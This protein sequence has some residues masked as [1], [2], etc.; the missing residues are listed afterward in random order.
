MFEQLI[1]HDEVL[2]AMIKE[3]EDS[4]A[5]KIADLQREL[6]DL[7]MARS[8]HM[9]AKAK[10]ADKDE[11]MMLDREPSPRFVQ[12]GLTGC[13]ID[14]NLADGE[15]IECALCEWLYRRDGSGGRFYYCSVEH[16]EDDF[17]SFLQPFFCHLL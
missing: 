3:A 13:A 4:Q 1:P 15:I 14:V 17:V 16:A 12:C 6:N 10:K 2:S 5:A 11:R 9:K 7:Q 8:A